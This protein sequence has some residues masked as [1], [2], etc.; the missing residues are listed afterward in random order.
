MTLQIVTDNGSEY[1]NKVIK[2]TLQEKHINYVTTSYY[3]PQGNSKEG[4]FNWTLHDAM[5]KKVSDNLDIW[6]IYLNQAL[7][8]IR[9]NF[10]ESSKFSPFYLLFNH[11]PV[12]PIDNILKPMSRY[13]G[14]EHCKISLEQQHWFVLMV[15]QHLKKAKWR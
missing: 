14:E 13:I 5:S 10:N 7:A 4:W 3:D 11:E 6:D 2:H 8:V 15:H 1:I 12:L 9:F